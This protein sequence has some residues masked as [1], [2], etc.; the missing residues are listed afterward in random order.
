MASTTGMV[1]ALVISAVSADVV[2]GRRQQIVLVGDVPLDRSAWLSL[3]LT[4]TT[5]IWRLLLPFLAA[6]VGVAF[7]GAP[8]AVTAIRNLTPE[9]AGAGSGV[10]TAIRQV[11]T[12][13][14]S[15]S[16][17]GFMHW[18]VIRQLPPVITAHE[19]GWSGD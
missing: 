19:R 5:P 10:F 9:L 12:V 6:G 1:S 7:L 14:G 8:L 16:M 2:G 15:A 17:A 18:L 3:E 4:P 13:L 11:G